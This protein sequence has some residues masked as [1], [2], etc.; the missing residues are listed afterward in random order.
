MGQ[1]L[2]NPQDIIWYFGNLRGNAVI[3]WKGSSASVWNFF[4]KR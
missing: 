4:F 1:T 3:L 2:E